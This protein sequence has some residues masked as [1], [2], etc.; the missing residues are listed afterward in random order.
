MP[1]IFDLID[2]GKLKITQREIGMKKID[3]VDLS[4]YNEI[5]VSVIETILTSLIV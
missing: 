2:K 1:I 5:E 3:T 4:D